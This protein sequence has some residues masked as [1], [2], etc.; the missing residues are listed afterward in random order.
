MNKEFKPPYNISYRPEGVKTVFLAGSIEMGM[1]ENWQ[2]EMTNYFNSMNVVVF[3]PRRD[4]WNSDWTQ[5]YTDPQ[6]YQ[7]VNWELSALDTADAIL[8]YFD[9]DTKSAISLLELGLYADSG[10][11]S[12]VCPDGFWKKGNVEAVCAKYNIP[13]YTSLESFKDSFTK[14]LYKNTKQQ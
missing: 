13:M 1:A 4:D 10:K 2:V 3:N 8:M 9:K 6:F 14:L 7:Q 12:V 5:E 11:I